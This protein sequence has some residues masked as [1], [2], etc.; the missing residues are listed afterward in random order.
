M[1]LDIVNYKNLTK[2]LKSASCFHSKYSP[3]YHRILCRECDQPTIGFFQPN[4]VHN[5]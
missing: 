3:K 5:S 1:R 2:D 4:W